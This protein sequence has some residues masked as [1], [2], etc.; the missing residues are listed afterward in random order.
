MLFSEI[1]N[2]SAYEI[3]TEILQAGK[4]KGIRW[5]Y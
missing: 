1:L 3:L 5:H 4:H 2:H